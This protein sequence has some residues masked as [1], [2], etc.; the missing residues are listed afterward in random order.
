MTKS[1]ALK[2]NYPV[3]K[4]NAIIA[5]GKINWLLAPFKGNCIFFSYMDIYYNEVETTKAVEDI[6]ADIIFVG[7]EDE[8]VTPIV[9]APTVIQTP[10]TNLFEQRRYWLLKCLS[11]II[12]I[13][14]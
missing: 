8:T 5:L 7:Y 12:F 4:V 3:L 10:S 2:V 6:N 1:A 14:T 11:R 9:V 13:L